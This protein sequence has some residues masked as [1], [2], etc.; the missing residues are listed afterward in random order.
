MIVLA[1]TLLVSAPAAPQEQRP[2]LYVDKIDLGE[3]EVFVTYNHE[4]REPPHPDD[5]LDVARAQC[6]RMGYIDAVRSTDPTLRQ[7][8]AI[9]PGAIC[10]RERATDNF[11]CMRGVR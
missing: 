4:T 11:T 8:M 7:C 6:R 2:T 3:S 1:S 9:G 10:M 5:V